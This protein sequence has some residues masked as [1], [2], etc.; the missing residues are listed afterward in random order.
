MVCSQDDYHIVFLITDLL[1]PVGA[2]LTG[3]YVAGMRDDDGDRFFYFDGNRVLKEF[4]NVESQLDRGAGIELSRN[5]G[6][7]HIRN[8]HFIRLAGPGETKADDKQR[9][10]Q[11][12]YFH[13]S[14]LLLCP[15]P[16]N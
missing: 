3:V 13:F 10:A 12:Y 11:S 14:G 1:E 4:F 6:F 2:D 5:G 9:K 8:R 7:T 16:G 15:H